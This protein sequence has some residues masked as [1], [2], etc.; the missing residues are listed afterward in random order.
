MSSSNPDIRSLERIISSMLNKQLQQICSSH[1]LKT[2]GVK[3]DLQNRIKNA[4][5]E[6]YTSEP[7]SYNAIRNT[8]FSIRGGNSSQSNMVSPSGSGSQA[9]ALNSRN[10]YYGDYYP[11]QTGSGAA[12][13]GHGYNGNGGTLNTFRS[14]QSDN[15]FKNTP[16]YTIETRIGALNVC[17]VMNN[18]RNSI[19]ITLKSS[20][21]PD[22]S[23][24]ATYP[25]MKVM[26]FCGS[27]NTGSQDI[28]FPHQSE[29]KV[30][31]SDIKHN[32]RGLK[33]KPGSTHPVDVTPFL[34]LKQSHYNNTVEFTYALTNKKFYLA[35]YLCKTHSID[36]LVTRI[37]GKKISKASVIRDISKKANDPDVVATSQVLSLLCPLSYTRLK[38]P[39]R[40]MSCN[41]V[42]CFDGKSFMQL[43]EQGPTW[44]CPIC[45]KAAPFETLAIDEYVQEVLEK[46][47]ESLEQVTIEPDGR[48]RNKTE[49]PEP[50]RSRPTVDSKTDDDDDLA[51]LSDS[52][53]LGNGITNGSTNGRLT[54]STPTRSLIRSGTPATQR[55]GSSK[56]PIEVIDLTFSSDEDDEPIVRAPKRQYQGP[57]PNA[58]DFTS[59][60]NWE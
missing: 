26:V 36:E 47:P 27:E 42:Q 39:C 8:I 55:S 56:R 57:S 44:S 60:Y 18:H 37:K 20:E 33:N 22:L 29:L 2:S 45:Y 34:R 17:P 1:G 13:Q 59:P 38:V 23:R 12:Q 3:A 11:P 28:L 14:P 25:P 15:L 46:T 35:L 30:N 51:I 10:T 49:E 7:P 21:H 6:N 43:Q 24:C 31:G 48:W 53:G 52:H 16:F 19:N 58:V 4:L 50:K 41:H 40:G 32:L 5:H 9:Q 54:L